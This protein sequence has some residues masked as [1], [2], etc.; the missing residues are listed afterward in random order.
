[1]PKSGDAQADPSGV[2]GKRAVSTSVVPI[3][4]ALVIRAATPAGTRNRSWAA[5]PSASTRV[6]PVAGRVTRDWAAPVRRRRSVTRRLLRSSSLSDAPVSSSRR[7]GTSAVRPTRQAKGGRPQ[8]QLHGPEWGVASRTRPGSGGRGVDPALEA[9]RRRGDRW[10]RGRPATCP[11]RT[12]SGPRRPRLRRAAGPRTWGGPP[13]PDCPAPTPGPVPPPA[14]PGRRPGCPAMPTT[15]AVA[16]DPGRTPRRRSRPRC[17]M[18]TIGTVTSVR[19]A[20]PA[21]VEMQD[22]LEEE[23]ARPGTARCP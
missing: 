13:A 4:M 14:V 17:P 12:R 3:A 6:T 16:R 15:T 23:E 2:R 22:A 7:S 1:M 9:S 11:R 8:L 5:P 18:I 10:P 19:F 21:A 20:E